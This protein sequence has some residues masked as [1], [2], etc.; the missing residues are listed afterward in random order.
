[1]GLSGSSQ[2]TFSIDSACSVSGF[3][4]LFCQLKNVSARFDK[5]V[6]FHPR[7]PCKP[8]VFRGFSHAELWKN[9]WKVWKTFGYIILNFSLV[10]YFM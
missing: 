3:F 10:F 6:V 2:P 7:T 1:M 4:V 8:P 9:L 5:K